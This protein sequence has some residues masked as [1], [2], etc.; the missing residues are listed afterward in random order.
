MS[1]AEE[2]LY[3]LGF[4]VF[5][6]IGPA[7]FQKLLS[8]FGS[9]KEAWMASE[10]DLKQ[11][12][13]GDKLIKKF[14]DFRLQFSPYRYEKVLRQNRIDFIAYFEE[15]Y[16]ALLARSKYPPI[17]LFIKGNYDFNSPENQQ[18]LAVVGCRKITEYGK[19]VTE[20]ITRDIVVA[21]FTVIS[22]LALGVDALAHRI[23]LRT[24]GKTIAVLGSGIDCCYPKEN[25]ALYNQITQHG[26]VVSEY[27]I[28]QPPT[29][30]SFPSRNRVIAGLA[31]GII[32]TE[33]AAD[34]GALITAEHAFANKRP[35]FAV[36]GPITSPFSQGPHLL[37][38]RGARLVTCAE[39]VLAVLGV[40]STASSAYSMG[41][42]DTRRQIKGDTKEE[43]MIIDLLQKQNL[44]FDEIV[45]ML[46]M[47]SAQIGSLLSLMEMKGMVKVLDTG[48]FSLTAA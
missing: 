27:P 26:A 2:R 14:I 24:Q 41:R 25:I 19:E 7:R 40:R 4:S 9:A 21:G 46:H 8:F 33:G 5:P 44:H 12:R 10:T 39:E 18:V 38:E 23:A 16:P 45:R 20:Q 13:L 29:I 17:A 36:P 15:R 6:G 31:S 34:S 30:G 11:M 42:K 47:G 1:N 22:G 28:G 3:W 32:V 35:V 37:I 48:Y 43:Q